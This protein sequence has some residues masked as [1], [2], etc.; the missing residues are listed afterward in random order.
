MILL[1]N[2]VLW[3]RFLLA[4]GAGSHPHYLCKLTQRHS[5][6]RLLAL[7]ERVLC[8]EGPELR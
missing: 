3:G 6:R 2:S 5:V 8:S 4:T 1:P 7:F